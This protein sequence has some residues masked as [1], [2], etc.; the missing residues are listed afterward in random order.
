MSESGKGGGWRRL[1]WVAAG[2]VGGLL[3][4]GA[5]VWAVGRDEGGPRMFGHRSFMH[6]F[7]HGPMD[8]EK[9]RDHV[10]TGVR[11]LMAYVDGTPEQ[12]DRVQAIAQ[13]ALEDL[14]PLRDR[15]HANRA[16]IH[17]ALSGASVDRAA[18]EEARRA[19]LKLAD[20]ASA[21]LTRALADAA[22]VLTPEQRTQLAEA[23][24]RFHR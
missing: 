6:R 15:H 20:E 17:G 21:R 2:L 12:R 8:P 19:E 4:G 18:L 16:A 3:A 10:Q 13:G 23:A 22:E 7:H 11:W 9:A 5:S 24:A 1:P 14:L